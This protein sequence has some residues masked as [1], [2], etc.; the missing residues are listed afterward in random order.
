MDL[1]PGSLS[2]GSTE[3][4]WAGPEGLTGVLGRADHDRRRVVNA[5]PNE[6]NDA[7]LVSLGRGGLAV[8]GVDTDPVKHPGRGGCD[9]SGGALAD[10]HHC[11][12]SAAR[13]TLQST[14]TVG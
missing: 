3:Q 4:V 6:V 8:C 1:T 2:R 9:R 10:D 13:S 11:L 12:S 5:P 14:L 7:R